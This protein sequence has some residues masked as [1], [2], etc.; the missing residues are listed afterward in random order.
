MKPT[1]TLL[2]D[3]SG[4]VYV[5]F[6]GAFMPLLTV[7]LCVAQLADLYATKLVVRHAAHRT[8]RAGIVV[9]PD[10]PAHYE[11]VGKLEEVRA[12]GYAVLAS[13]RSISDAEIEIPT[14]EEYER[15]EP[16]TVVVRATTRCIF[17]IAN[18][19]L[20]SAGDGEPSRVLEATLSMPAHAA[21]Y[22]YGQ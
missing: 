2:R 12:A 9:F 17:P 21:R 3:R 19:L 22:E 15:A 10:D 13:K 16:V 5:E 1:T 20:C 11:A 18:R 14:G 8:A 6:I 7:F 4:A